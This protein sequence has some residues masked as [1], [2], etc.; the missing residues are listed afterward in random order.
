MR[1]GPLGKHIVYSLKI[2]H[3]LVRM[4]HRK[5]VS[6]MERSMIQQ[7]TVSEPAS[8]TEKKSWKDYLEV[9]KPGINTHNILVTFAGFWL[10]A[11]LQTLNHFS[12]LIFTLL[13]T[14]LV[15]AG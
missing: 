1:F 9:T 13:G 6:H 12:L 4:V 5:E 2:I 11:G 10:A 15:I 3:A 7:T 14:M 8:R